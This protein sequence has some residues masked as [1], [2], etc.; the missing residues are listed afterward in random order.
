MSIIL[1]RDLD[2]HYGFVDLTPADRQVEDL[3]TARGG[4]VNGLCG[5][6]FPGVL[7]MITGLHTGSVPFEVAVFD[8]EPAVPD[9]WEDVVE[10]SF[11]APD[12]D[13]LL[14]TFDDGADLVLPAATSY[15]ARYCASGMD[16]ADQ[17]G[18]RTSD[19]PV[20]DRYLLQLWP[21]PMREDVV[22]RQTSQ[23][24]AY[25][26]EVARTTA[27]PPPPLT[28]QQ[29]ASA[30]AREAER[31]AREEAVTQ[32][33]IEL[34]RWG[35][36][37]PS[38]TLRSGGMAAWRL[39]NTDRGLADQIA[40]LD[41]IGLQQVAHWAAS[42]ACAQAG[43]G[44][45]DWEPALKA[46]G[47][48]R[49]LPPP[50]DDPDEAWE[51]LYGPQQLMAAFDESADAP[52]GADVVRTHP[53]AAALATVLAAA[54]ANPATAAFDALQQA[55]SAVDDPGELL[56]ALRREFGLG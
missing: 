44:A 12:R 26:H 19:E 51:R 20:V 2:V 30:A 15:R 3:L 35:G 4:Q 46:L 55:A 48:G 1:S 31:L 50:F 33:R 34:Q 18:V 36:S 29:Q 47:E 13:Y 5:A 25:W 43:G 23:V 39:A 40:S 11:A 9:E 14:S 27:P 7:A 37:P 17:A 38:D 6:R 45:L 53:P 54:N 42:R 21:A 16:E 49:T 8:A 52:V 32:D 56:A 41:P 10:V 28:P 24:A 22:L